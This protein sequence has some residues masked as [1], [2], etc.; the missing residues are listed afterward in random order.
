MGEEKAQT[1]REREREREREKK[2]R[3]EYIHMPNAKP[4]RLGKST[5]M[6]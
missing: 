2:K 4:E 1:E 6:S 5:V 3:E